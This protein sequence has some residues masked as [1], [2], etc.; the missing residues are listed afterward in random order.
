MGD[1][2]W[3]SLVAGAF[4]TWVLILLVVVADEIIDKIRSPK[5]PAE[6][7]ETAGRMELIDLR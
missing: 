2:H 3:P 4:V 5:E 6:P 1:L 7:A